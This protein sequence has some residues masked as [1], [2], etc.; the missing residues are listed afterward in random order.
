MKG[1]RVVI[2]RTDVS[3]VDWGLPVTSWSMQEAA[4]NKALVQIPGLD[5]SIHAPTGRQL[6]IHRIATHATYLYKHNQDLVASISWWY[7]KF[8]KKPWWAGICDCSAFLKV[9]A[10]G[11][12]MFEGAW[13]AMRHPHSNF[14]A[15]FQFLLKLLCYLYVVIAELYSSYLYLGFILL[16]V[17][18]T[19]IAKCKM[20]NLHLVLSNKIFQRMTDVP[21]VNA[22][23][24]SPETS[25]WTCWQ[26]VLNLDAVPIEQN[27]SAIVYSEHC[28]QVLSW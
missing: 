14:R 9:D 3:R 17:L 19:L 5:W 22:Y 27:I 7:Y 1:A 10:Q 6:L 16:L 13:V 8:P 26:D 28:I 24:T 11:N 4:G 2:G 18:L 15:D 21:I 25:P 20:Q 12:K 23:W